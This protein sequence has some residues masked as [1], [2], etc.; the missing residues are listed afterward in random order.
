MSESKHTP[1]QMSKTDRL[2]QLTG[3][4]FR[5]FGGGQG[6]NWNPIVN[7]LK[8]NPLQFAAGVDI[9][10]VVNFILDQSGFDKLLEACKEG[11]KY[12]DWLAVVTGP[13]SAAVKYGPDFTPP[14][15]EELYDECMRV[16]GLF[17]AAIAEVDSWPGSEQS[18][19]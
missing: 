7:A 19:G 16:R 17:E 15:N 6:S 10:D 8:D 3:Q 2:T 18:P 14:T 4:Q 9:K 12:Y 1:K 13:L 5:S 11:A